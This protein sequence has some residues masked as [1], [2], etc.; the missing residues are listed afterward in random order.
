MVVPKNDKLA[1]SEKAQPAFPTTTDSRQ[2]I[3]AQAG[4]AQTQG[5]SYWQQSS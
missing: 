5:R 3:Q 2:L 1:A 4:Q